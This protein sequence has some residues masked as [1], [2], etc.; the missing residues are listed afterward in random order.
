MKATTIPFILLQTSVALS[1]GRNRREF[2]TKSLIGGV[3]GIILETSCM[4]ASAAELYDDFVTSDS[5]LK[6]KV[7]KEGTGAIPTVGDTLKA[8]YIGW[9]DGFD[10]EKKFDGNRD[11]K[12]PFAF[13]VGK[14]QVIRGWDES[15]LNMAVGERRQVIVPPRSGYGDRGVAGIVPGNSTLYFDVELIEISSS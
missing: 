15:F 5:G 6:Y 11:S 4:P 9:L 10:S 13:T 3:T 12:R 8:D 14:G 7:I 1:I 2:V